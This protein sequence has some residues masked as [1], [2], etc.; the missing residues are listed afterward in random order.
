MIKKQI[1]KSE[2]DDLGKKIYDIVVNILDKNTLLGLFLLIEQY[3]VKIKFYKFLL[4]HKN[5]SKDE[6]MLEAI[7]YKQQYVLSN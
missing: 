5:I 1:K 4:K 6:L 2:L 7:H 3:P